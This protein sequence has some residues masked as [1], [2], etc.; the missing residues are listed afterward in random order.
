MYFHC[1]NKSFLIGADIGGSHISIASIDSDSMQ[2]F[3]KIFREKIN[4]DITAEN[5]ISVLTILIHQCIASV[6]EKELAAICLAF[7]GAFDYENGI[8][9]YDGS[10]KKFE[11]LYGLNIRET[12]ANKLQISAPIFFCNDALS[13]SL[14]EYQQL[15]DPSINMMAITLGSGLGSSFINNFQLLSLSDSSLPNNGELYNWPYKEGV[16]EDY[17]SSKALVKSYFIKTGIQ[18]DGVKTIKVHAD[19]Q[20]QPAINLFTDFGT[21]LGSFLLHWSNQCGIKAIVIG[22]SIVGAWDYFYPSIKQVFIN[23]QNECVIIPSAN[24][25]Q[26]SMLGSVVAYLH[27]A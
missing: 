2:I 22:G 17:F 25:E 19:N 16:A 9:L 20:E 11:H 26:S 7:P 23:A 21:A 13:F 12:L 8:G 3:G 5:F 4:T 6:Q 10:N 18:T 24:P 27:K 15:H 14:G 1:M